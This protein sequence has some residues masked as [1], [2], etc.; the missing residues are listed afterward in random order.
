MFNSFVF[1]EELCLCSYL[2]EIKW[3]VLCEMQSSG[4]ILLLPLFILSG[5][6]FNCLPGSVSL[7]HLSPVQSHGL[8]LFW[9]VHSVHLWTTSDPLEIYLGLMFPW[10]GF[11][12]LDLHRSIIP[13]KSPEKCSLDMIPDLKAVNPLKVKTASLFE[14]KSMKGWWPCYADKDGS[15]VMAVCMSISWLRLLYSFSPL[16]LPFMSRFALDKIREV[17]LVVV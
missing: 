17:K 11:L 8:P 4:Q 16:V 1:A 15:R 14:Q 5:K 9:Q 3:V 6:K 2:W 7:T 12:E 10:L 13:A